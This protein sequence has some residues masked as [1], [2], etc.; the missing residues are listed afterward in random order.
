M[1]D[2]NAGDPDLCRTGRRDGRGIA[3]AAGVALTTGGVGGRGWIDLDASASSRRT[4]G[5]RCRFNRVSGGVLRER[6][7]IPVELRYCIAISVMTDGP[8]V[9]SVDPRN[10]TNAATGR[11]G[12][13][14]SVV[15]AVV[16]AHLAFASDFNRR[17]RRTV[18]VGLRA[19]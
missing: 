7:V 19:E 16:Q 13:L 14:E 2:G 10:N 4:S 11:R 6:T 15:S 12:I 5:K 17:H 3:G 18:A 9:L 1:D 8:D